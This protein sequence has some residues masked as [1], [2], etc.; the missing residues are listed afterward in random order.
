MDSVFFELV[1]LSNIVNKTWTVDLVKCLVLGFEN[2][3]LCY[4][5]TRLSSKYN[6][7]LS[8]EIFR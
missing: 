2:V 7:L 3:C 1:G 5:R 8:S 6:W 4:L